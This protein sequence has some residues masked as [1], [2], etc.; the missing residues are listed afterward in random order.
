MKV[1]KTEKGQ[2]VIDGENKT[3]ILFQNGTT[4]ESDKSIDPESILFQNFVF[5][6][7]IKGRRKAYI[8]LANT[9]KKQYYF[10]LCAKNGEIIATGETYKKKE[11]VV[12][13]LINNFQDFEIV[14]TTLTID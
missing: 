2:I 7:Y 8:K 11:S 12:K 9:K 10:N 4:I 14:D 3:K 13:M 1:S 6:R 5:G